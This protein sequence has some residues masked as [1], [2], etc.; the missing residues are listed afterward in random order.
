LREAAGAIASRPAPKKVALV[1]SLVEEKRRGREPCKPWWARQITNFS[2][3]ANIW[4][5]GGNQ[6][7][8]LKPLR[9]LTRGY[10]QL[11]VK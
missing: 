3:V 1:V 4:S 7:T 2:A 5:L 9:F 11:P 6:K 10:H 8:L